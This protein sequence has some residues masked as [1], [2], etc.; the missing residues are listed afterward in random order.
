MKTTMSFGAAACSLLFAGADIMPTGSLGYP[1]DQYLVIE[2]TRDF[3]PTKF[4]KD[5]K[6]TKD[7][8]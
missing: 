3:G 4:A 2:G 8:Q 7:P 1:L 6:K 5:E